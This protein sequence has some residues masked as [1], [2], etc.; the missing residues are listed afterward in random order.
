MFRVL[1]LG[2]I[3]LVSGCVASRYEPPPSRQM[4]KI[5]DEITISK[6]FDEAW[7]DLL[8]YFSKPDFV[9][10]EVAQDL[11]MMSVSFKSDE[12]SDYVDCGHYREQ[13][14][15]SVFSGAYTDYLETYNRPTVVGQ[16]NIEVNSVTDR[17]THLRISTDYRVVCSSD[18]W[19][20]NSQQVSTITTPRATPG[21]IPTRSC[22]ST[23][24]PE[25]RLLHYL[26]AL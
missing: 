10:G 6:S 8:S 5:P 3:M 19:E 4:V 24:R 21:T 11:G 22:Q 2:S 25:T 9:M 23:H 20:F 12:I 13:D 7:S 16:M 18:V 1:L 26:A 14:G 15:H 17:R